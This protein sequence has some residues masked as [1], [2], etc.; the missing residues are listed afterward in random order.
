MADAK[1]LAQCFIKI[2][3]ADMNEEFMDSLIEVVVDS[4][5]YLPDMVTIA[6]RD[7]KL[8]WVDDA[9]ADS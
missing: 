1:F 3:G 8:Q 4:S 2:N 7:V 5:L 6:V 9:K